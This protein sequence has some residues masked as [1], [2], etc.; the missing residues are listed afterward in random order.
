MNLNPL[1][2][3]HY[4][5]IRIFNNRYQRH[6]C[7]SLAEHED[8][9]LPI[10]GEKKKTKAAQC[11]HCLCSPP[12]CTVTWFIFVMKTAS[13]FTCA[14]L[15]RA[16]ARASTCVPFIFNLRF[17][18]RRAARVPAT[19]VDVV[20]ANIDSEKRRTMALIF[21]FQW[22]LCQSAVA[23]SNWASSVHPRAPPSA[24][25][26]HIFAPRLRTRPPLAH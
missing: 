11:A 12:W 26:S 6:F 14:Q 4:S 15:D 23:D 20:L 24:R 19:R 17:K 18:S 5:R 21:C 22:P 8:R 16:E 9:T 13:M 3:S 1:D 10:T 7:G 2:C 25:A